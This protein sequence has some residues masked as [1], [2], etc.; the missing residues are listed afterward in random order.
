MEGIKFID[1]V[2]IDNA[3]KLGYKIKL[4]GVSEIIDNKVYQRVHPTLIKKSSYIGTIDSVLNAVIVE[5]TPLGQTIIQGEGAG[6]GPT[7]SSLLS[8][9]VFFWLCF[10]GPTFIASKVFA[11]NILEAYEILSYCNDAV[12]EVDDTF[13]PDI[14]AWCMDSCDNVSTAC[15]GVLIFLGFNAITLWFKI[16][17]NI[18]VK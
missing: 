18:R 9:I 8:D 16:L 7:S 6:P 3:N 17:L 11:L 4:L 13:S 1:K 5:G 10:N 15:S 14:I 2:D 12:A